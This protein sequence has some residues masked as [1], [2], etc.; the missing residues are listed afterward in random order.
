MGVDRIRSTKIAPVALSTSYL[1]GSASL[2]ISTMTLISSGG[3]VPVGTRS[4]P[5]VAPMRQPAAVRR[6]ARQAGG[7]RA[8]I[9]RGGALRRDT[10]ASSP[11]H[12]DGKGNAMG[13]LAELKRRN[14]VRMAGLYLVGAWLVVQVADTVFP[15]F[16]LPGWMLRGVIVLLAVGF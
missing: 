6:G 9:L 10:G 11:G 3:F 13:L 12:P 16:G 7:G 5:M 15:A 14:V 8:R 2:G 1:T 4:R